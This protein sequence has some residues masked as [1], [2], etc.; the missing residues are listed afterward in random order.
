MEGHQR[1]R[2]PLFVDLHSPELEG[3][4]RAA[5]VYVRTA[6]PLRAVRTVTAP[7]IIEVR[8]K[9]GTLEAREPAQEGDRVITGLEDEQ[10][11]LTPERFEAHYQEQED[12]SYV[13]TARRIVALPN[14]F[15]RTIQ[16]RAP[17]GMEQ[18]TSKAFL[19]AEL[20]AHGDLTDERYLIGD[21][22]LLLDHYTPVK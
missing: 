8:L 18:G 3:A 11:V 7:E 17:W 1:E 21:E 16:V 12:G 6:E 9:D 4:L 15:R 14:P 22:N 20:N 19:I 10:Y 5:P 2:A 13:P